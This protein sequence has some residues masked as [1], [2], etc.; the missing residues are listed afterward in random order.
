[1][2][3]VPEDDMRIAIVGAGKLG[4]AF[5][6]ALQQHGA[7]VVAATSRSEHGRARATELLGIDAGSDPTDV[8]G[9][10]PL[11]LIAVP[12]D[13]IRATADRLAE[14]IRAG[15]ECPTMVI[16]CSG[17]ATISCLDALAEIGC[18][19]ASIHPVQTVTDGGEAGVLEHATAAVSADTPAVLTIAFEIA[20]RAG[21]HPIELSDDAKSLHHAACTLAANFTVALLAA[22]RDLAVASG[23]DTPTLLEAYARLAATA[24]ARVASLGPEQALTG[25]VARGDWSTVARHESAIAASAPQ[26]SELYA[27]LTASTERLAHSREVAHAI[28]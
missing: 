18:S 14:A 15:A 28:D 12:D 26:H 2:N 19:V 21:M 5:G 17:S 22:A 1:M 16:H 11:L 3:D 7:T 10:A 6:R 4:C 9:S 25:P 27:T 8:L 23:V 24:A 13:D 20:Q